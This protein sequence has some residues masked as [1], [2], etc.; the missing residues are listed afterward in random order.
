MAKHF[1]PPPP[2]PPRGAPLRPTFAPQHAQKASECKLPAPG[3]T[4]TGR[5]HAHRPGARPEAGCTPTG[6][7][8]A[9]RPGAR[10]EPGCTPRGRVHAHR[11][12]ARPEAGCTPTG[13]V[14]AHRPV[15]PQSQSQS[16]INTT[17]MGVKVAPPLCSVV[18]WA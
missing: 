14:H 7:V 10:P 5:V 8:H 2:P 9:H 3:S 4:P 15:H 13:R 12:G 11:P 16:G 17:R 1:L 18:T 6:R